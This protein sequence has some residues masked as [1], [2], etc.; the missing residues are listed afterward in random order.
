MKKINLTLQALA[1]LSL[2]VAAASSQDHC[3]VSCPVCTGDL[4]TIHS[5]S[6]KYTGIVPNESFSWFTIYVPESHGEEEEKGSTSFTLGLFD[7]FEAGLTLGLDSWDLRGRG[8]VLL[9]Q[10]KK[11]IPGLIV[12][13]G[14]IRPSGIETNGYLMLTKGAVWSSLPLHGY[15]GVAKKFEKNEVEEFFGLSIGF[16]P[17]IGA[18]AGYDGQEFHV[19]VAIQPIGRLNAGVM[20]LDGKEFSLFTGISGQ[21]P[22]FN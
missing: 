4:K 11:I 3:G 16:V 21:I 14:N 7:R 8:K 10:E 9:L 6:G 17:K 15:F 20:L 5:D 18:M 19:G 22:F 12:G 13:I 2:F 1:V